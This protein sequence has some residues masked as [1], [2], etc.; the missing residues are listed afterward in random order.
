[1]KKYQFK[2]KRCPDCKKL[3]GNAGAMGRHWKGIHYSPPPPPPPPKP[4]EL[5]EHVNFA[6]LVD[7]NTWG[8]E[9]TKA[10]RKNP[11]TETLKLGV[12]FRIAKTLDMIERAINRERKIL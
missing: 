5:T 7:G 4:P 3:F 10:Q 11:S 6:D 8:M 9:M 2:K 12:L 1:M